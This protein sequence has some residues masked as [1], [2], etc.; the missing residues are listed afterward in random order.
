[1]VELKI[2]QRK[3]KIFIGRARSGSGNLVLTVVSGYSRASALSSLKSVKIDC[4]KRNFENWAC[5]EKK[6]EYG[7]IR[8]EGV[9]QSKSSAP[10]SFSDYQEVTIDE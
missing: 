4:S 8:K 7:F 2:R 6:S 5:E 10:N 9:W 3:L 1:M